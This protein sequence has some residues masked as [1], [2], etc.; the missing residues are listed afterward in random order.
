MSTRGGTLRGKNAKANP[1]L[2]VMDEHLF[3]PLYAAMG[4]YAG[5]KAFPQPSTAMPVIL[6]GNWSLNNSYS[7]VGVSHS[8]APWNGTWGSQTG[9][10]LGFSSIL[11]IT[12]CANTNKR[13]YEDKGISF[14]L[15]T[16]AVQQSWIY[17]LIYLFNLSEYRQL[18]TLR[19]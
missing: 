14:F 15:C 16:L 8:P 9:T 11:G 13:T 17:C 6:K 19:Y 12:S 3:S 4:R 5:C 7:T 10:M 2:L 18:H 1:Q